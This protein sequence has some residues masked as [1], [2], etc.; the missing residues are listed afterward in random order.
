MAGFQILE[1]VPS[2]QQFLMGL[3]SQ[4]SIPI[5]EAEF[6]LNSSAI[7]VRIEFF[8]YHAKT[9]LFKCKNPSN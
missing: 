9:P 1:R 8:T 4:N 3:Q 2:L 5:E 6:V 7:F